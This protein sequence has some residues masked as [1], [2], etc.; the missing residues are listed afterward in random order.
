M[1]AAH[2]DYTSLEHRKEV[3]DYWGVE[4][5]PEKPGLTAT[6]LF[7]ALESG[8]VKA[9]WVACTN[10]IVSLPDA[11]RAEAALKKAELVMVSDAYHPTDTTK[12]AHIL[13]PA[14]GWAEKE[15]CV[16]NSERCITHLQQA[17]PAPGLSRPDWKITADFALRLGQYLGRDWQYAFAYEKSED[18][19]LEHCA[20]TRNMDVDISG[21]S[22]TVLDEHGPQQWP[23][24]DGAEPGEEKRLYADGRFETKDRKGRFIA[25]TY[26][27]VAESTDT[28]YPLSLTTGRIR[29]QWHT[30]TKTGNVPSLMQHLPLPCLQIHPDSAADRAIGEEDLVRVVSRRGEVVVPVQFSRD[31][32]SDTVFLPMHWGRMTARNGCAN[33]LTLAAVDPVSKQPEFKHTAVQVEG[34]KPAWRGV[35]LMAGSKLELG[36]QMIEGYTY[37]VV[38]CAGSDHPVTSVDLA[39]TKP[40]KTEQYKRLDQ[41]LEQ[42]ESF[43]T[44]TYSDRKHG[45]NRKAWLSDGRLMAVRW[46]GGDIHEVQ[47]LRKLMLEGRDVG[48]LR[49]YLLAPGGPINKEDSKGK[50]ICACQNVGEL[51]LKAAIRDGSDTIEALK[52]STMAGTG[53]GSCVPEIK[54]LLSV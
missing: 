51:E 43:E 47:W 40:V 27:P 35:M 21:L 54:R 26:R 29:D 25:V 13:F 23:Y 10:P 20:L 48:E 15:G 9:V 6:E 28:E 11:R 52:A 30:M 3:A 14:A 22:Y 5:V 2:R 39:C 16:T 33:S 45:I 53:C 1:L 32:R 31:I 38:S 24:P 50:I 49:P 8:K 46:V 4:A 36:R 44:L 18:V 41:M 34:F 19:F 42:G 7:D 12:F 17:L 37:G